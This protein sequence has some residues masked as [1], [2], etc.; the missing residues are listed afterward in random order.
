MDQKLGIVLGRGLMTPD[1]RAIVP[2]SWEVPPEVTLD[3]AAGLLCWTGK[4]RLVRSRTPL[5]PQFLKLR[6]KDNVAILSFAKQW[7]PLWL[8][9]QHQLPIMHRWV[10]NAELARTLAENGAVSGCG[11]KNLGNGWYGEPLQAW[12]RVSNQA[13]YILVAGSLANQ[14]RLPFAVHEHL[15]ADRLGLPPDTPPLEIR[16]AYLNRL[17]TTEHTWT[18]LGWI[19]DA[20]EL[21]NPEDLP[22]ALAKVIVGRIRDAIG[23]KDQFAKTLQQPDA[24]AERINQWIEEGGGFRQKAAWQDGQAVWQEEVRSLYAAIGVGLWNVIGDMTTGRNC[25]HCGQVFTPARTWQKYCEE[26]G[27]RVR[28]R[29]S[30]RRSRANRAPQA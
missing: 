6:N 10:N 16:A 25:K 19:R 26:C 14:A 11:L 1:A 22:D 20:I 8:C 28:D 7:G 4:P 17:L 24:L 15:L 2:G 5:L 9:E 29:M 12:R 13:Y 23:S 21:G 27:K 18:S 3:E 30:Q